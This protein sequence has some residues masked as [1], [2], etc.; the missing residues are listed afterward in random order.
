MGFCFDSALEFFQ[1]VLD[2]MSFEGYGVTECSPLIAANTLNGQIAGTVGL[3]LQEVKLMTE[4]GEEIAH[5]DPKKSEYKG[6][7]NGIGELWVHG[8]HVMTGYLDDPERTAE[9]LVTDD[10]GKVW[11]RTGDLFSMDDE[12]YLTFQGRVGRQFKLKNGEFVNPERLERIFARVSLI[13][14]VLVCGDQSHTYPLPVVTVNTEEARLQTDIPD[15]PINDDEALRRHPAIADR[16]REQLLREAT[17]FG[18]PGHERPQKVLVLPAQFSE[19]TG[20]LTRGLKKVVPK[21]IVSDFE[22]EISETYGE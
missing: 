16:I 7:R 20:T 4:T 3:P 11:Y 14:H 17:D 1:N 5:G 10:A 19:E 21:K 15:L 18:L 22:K 12:G 8:D 2:I 9:V 6:S 13:E